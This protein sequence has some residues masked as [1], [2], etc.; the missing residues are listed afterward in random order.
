MSLAPPFA[1]AMSVESFSTMACVWASTS[2]ARASNREPAAACIGPVTSP[3]VY[4]YFMLLLARPYS[5][6]VAAGSGP[7]SVLQ[8][9]PGR[10]IRLRMKYVFVA[11]GTWRTAL[12]N[13]G[14]FAA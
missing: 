8:E 11:H 6:C 13:V 7:P 2:D 9:A 5:D 12:Y 10:A 1:V 3:R 4:R 14:S